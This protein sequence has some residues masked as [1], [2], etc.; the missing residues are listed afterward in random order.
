[1]IRSFKSFAA[2]CAMAVMAA[3]CTNTDKN[4]SSNSSSA[5]TQISSS[6]SSPEDTYVAPE[7]API[8]SSEILS[9]AATCTIN[10]SDSGIEASGKGAIVSSKIVTINTEGVYSL[11]GTS[12][13][14]K[15]LIEADKD[16]KITLI[17]NGLSLT[18][19]D[20]SAIDCEEAGELVVCT[21]SGT[22][23]SVCDTSNYTFEP[24]E[25]EPD[26][27][28]FCRSDLTLAGEGKLSVTGY[29][30]DGIKCKDNLQIINGTYTVKSESDAIVG[31]DSVTI[32]DGDISADSGKD[33]I[34]SSQNNDPT[35]GYVAINGGN[36]SIYAEHDGIQ[37]ETT[38]SVYSGN[39]TIVSGGDAAYASVQT[40]TETGPGGGHFG[41][42]WGNRNP[43]SG[44][45]ANENTQSLKGLKAGGDIAI[46]NKDTVLNITS[47]DDAVHSNANVTVSSGQL[48]LS[49]CDDAIHADETLKI[50]SGN[51][52]VIKS[53]EGLEGK[54]IE[55]DG[56]EID[57]ISADDGMNAAGGDN[58]DYFGFGSGSDEYYISIK[59][60]DVTVNAGGDGVDSNGS[61]AL[62]GGR[63]VI[64]GPTNSGNGALDYGTSFA[65]SGGE[66]IALGS[67][68]MAQAPSTLSQPCISITAN[69]SENSK[70]EVRAEDGTVIMSTTTPKVC[71]SLIF[72]SYNF[73]EGSTYSVYSGDTL[74]STVTAQNGVSG[75]GGSF[76]GG[77]GGGPGGNGGPGGGR[78][79][80][81]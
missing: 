74:L 56:G 24:E 62:S 38:L 45:S 77:F 72:S 51:I 63:L 11:S 9:Q 55:I 70:L 52:S 39:I 13:D 53:S 58:G 7:T 47:A 28:I 49:S 40:E 78:G 3:G 37:A 80:I 79:G 54:C 81:R 32:Y 60:G 43:N 16:D 4:N 75:N 64:Y 50:E 17:L 33:G 42:D 29:Y 30:N 10:F 35:L 59:G 21:A 6:S 26:A 20:G 1:M 34:K 66:L 76:G 23:N 48:T 2:I 19:K 65:V 25:T 69:V 57:I 5:G 14:A 61:I 44:S 41:G 8:G 67:V 31:K 15:I 46:Y 73:T 22:E 27:A 68:G 18:S 71:Q 36:I 12:S